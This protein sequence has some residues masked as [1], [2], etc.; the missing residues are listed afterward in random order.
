MDIR[1]P[2]M[3]EAGRCKKTEEKKGKW[4]DKKVKIHNSAYQTALGAVL[5]V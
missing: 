1:D 2:C 3:E 5:Y 4:Y